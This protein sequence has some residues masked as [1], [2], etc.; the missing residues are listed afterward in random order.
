[1]G[2]RRMNQRVTLAAVARRAGVAE[3]TASRIMNGYTQNF[4]VR[5]E[6]RERVLQ[7]AA[8]LNYR[9]NPM[10]R[11]IA[12]KR[13]NLVAVIGSPCGES[14]SLAVRAAASALLQHRIHVGTSF[15]EPPDL[16]F[17]VPSWRVDGVIAAGMVD[18]DELRA[19]TGEGTPCVCLDAS[20]PLDHVDSVC[21][22][23]PAAVGLALEHLLSNGWKDVIYVQGELGDQEHGSAFVRSRQATAFADLRPDERAAS[24]I[25]YG[26]GRSNQQIIDALRERA[27]PG[28]LAS[29]VP[30]AMRLVQITAEA[31]LRVG[32]DLAIVS[33][34]D[35][36]TGALVTPSLS[37]VRQPMEAIG[38]RAA[39]LLLERMS[40]EEDTPAPEAREVALSGE[41]IERSS[42][43]PMGSS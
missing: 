32:V 8:E 27:A 4:R 18:P 35:L 30:T 42:S 41:L 16:V 6:V 24:L 29:D 14:L 13:T 40:I 43:V 25:A 11:S 5:P 1:M 39:E 28:V 31:G 19:L 34:R 23:E 33:L 17:G 15:F 36:S 7:A 37:C 26:T 22:D 9:P 38:T 10:V 20:F 2:Q 12:A 3:S 21:V